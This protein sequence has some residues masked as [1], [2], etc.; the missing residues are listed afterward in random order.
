[1]TSLPKLPEDITERIEKFINVLFLDDADWNALV[2]EMVSL[3]NAHEPAKELMFKMVEAFDTFDIDKFRLDVPLTCE[4]LLA[5]MAMKYADPSSL[6]EAGGQ[7][8]GG[9]SI[10]GR[11]ALVKLINQAH[12]FKED[13]VAVRALFKCPQCQHSITESTKFCKACGH[14]LHGLQQGSDPIAASNPCPKCK[15]EMLAS[16]S[17]CEECGHQSPIINDQQPKD[18]ESHPNVCTK[19]Q[20]ALVRGA[21]FCSSC[22]TA[23]ASSSGRGHEGSS[24]AKL[25]QQKDIAVANEEY[26]HAHALQA[27]ITR[28]QAAMAANESVSMTHNGLPQNVK[29]AITMLQQANGN[30]DIIQQ[31]L[32]TLQQSPRGPNEPPARHMYAR[33][34]SCQCTLVQGQPQCYQC[35]TK[36]QPQTTAAAKLPSQWAEEVPMRASP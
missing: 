18:A 15:H 33:C 17:F 14:T 29:A 3:V 20:Q 5:I 36:V 35:G 25:I 16:D 34:T 9:K 12:S 28:L 10:R 19:C 31:V 13:V 7:L 27:E 8:H 23:N 4:N 22:G 6:L 11:P 21:A 24:L 1:M 30:A 2:T 26:L 32:A